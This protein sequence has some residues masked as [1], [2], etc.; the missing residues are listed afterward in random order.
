VPLVF[1]KSL[2]QNVTGEV[3]GGW[4]EA[5]DRDVQKLHST[6]YHYESK[7]DKTGVTGMRRKE[8]STQTFAMPRRRGKDNIKMDIKSK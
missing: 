7:H 2:R 5:C 4:K 3:T 1:V 8:I 6:K